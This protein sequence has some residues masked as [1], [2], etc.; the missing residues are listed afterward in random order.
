MAITNGYCTLS[1][2]KASLRITDSVDDALLELAVESASREIDQATERTFYNMGTATRVFVA[3]D[4]YFTEIDDLISID[5]LRTDPEGDNT[6]SVTWTSTDYQLEP[7]NG[8]SGGIP[9][10]Y[11][12]IRARDTYLFPQEEEEAL[13]EVRGVWG[14]SSVPTAI[15]QATVILASRIFKRND[16]PLGVAGFGDL[17]VIRVGKLDPDVEAL[18]HSFRK[19]RLA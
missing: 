1:E 8:F 10:P 13:V 17:G 11:T 6:F 19:P 14:W 9:S 12:S 18:I 7:L 15:K 5:R 2:V 3:R 4:P 16:S